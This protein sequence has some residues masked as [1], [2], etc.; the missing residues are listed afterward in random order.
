MKI[1]IRRPGS[2]EFRAVSEQEWQQYRLAGWIYFGPC[3]E[4]PVKTGPKPKKRKP[5]EF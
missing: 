1:K 2:D 3:E 4:E 5:N